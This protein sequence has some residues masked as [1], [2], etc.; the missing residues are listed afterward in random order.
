MQIYLQCCVANHLFWN[1]VYIYLHLLKHPNSHCHLSY[2]CSNSLELQLGVA[3]LWVLIQLF[4]LHLINRDYLINFFKFSIFR[5]ILLSVAF[6]F[7][8]FWNFDN[9]RTVR[10]GSAAISILNFN[11]CWWFFAFFDVNYLVL[12]VRSTNSEKII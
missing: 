5:L 4:L 11:L 2:S 10:M 7:T 8:S 1:F 9:G 3:G 6:I 12:F